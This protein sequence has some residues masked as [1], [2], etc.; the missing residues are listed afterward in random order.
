MKKMIM[1][2][3]E[4]T[5]NLVRRLV[6]R[7]VSWEPFYNTF[8]KR[9]S[10][11]TL[12]E[13]TMQKGAIELDGSGYRVL[14]LE[15]PEG[16]SDK[17]F[18]IFVDNIHVCHINNESGKVYFPESAVKNNYEL[19]DH[20]RK[21]LRNLSKGG[22][23]LNESFREYFEMKDNDDSRYDRNYESNIET[24]LSAIGWQIF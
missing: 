9:A 4:G 11:K 6:R 10:R 13:Y 12:V 18:N 2:I 17:G 24:H 7:I 1:K 22:L 14:K 21:I 16:L 19:V 15:R 8:R 20:T 5:L 23:R 3:L